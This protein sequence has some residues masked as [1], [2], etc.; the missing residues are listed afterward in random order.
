MFAWDAFLDI[1]DVT[2]SRLELE[3]TGPLH[4]GQHTTNPGVC[5]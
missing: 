5:V 3:H 4:T 2:F 1:F